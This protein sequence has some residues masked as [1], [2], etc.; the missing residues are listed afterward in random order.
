MDKNWAEGIWLNKS[1]GILRQFLGYVQRHVVYWYQMY[2]LH[3]ELDKTE[4]IIF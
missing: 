3:H 1:D 2:L 4:G